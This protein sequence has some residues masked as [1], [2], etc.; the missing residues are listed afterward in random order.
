MR[1]MLIAVGLLAAI[2]ALIIV[3]DVMIESAT[4]NAKTAG[5]AIPHDWG[6]LAGCR[7]RDPKA[8]WVPLANYRVM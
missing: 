1:E 4:C 6:F 2:L 5:L 7:V 8:G 3:I